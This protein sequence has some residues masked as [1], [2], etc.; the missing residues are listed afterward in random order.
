MRVLFACIENS[1]RSQIAEALAKNISQGKIDFYS[2]GSKP[3]GVV[4]PMAIKLL[5]SQRVH[6]TDH[7]SKHISEFEGIKINYL[8]LMGC[9]DECPNLVV[10]ERIEWDIPDPIDME[11]SEFLKV[12]EKIRGEVQK[13]IATI[14]I[15][16][17][18]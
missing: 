3:S 5:R 2:A 1:C 9:G 10:D 11:K 7:K 16:H 13:L 6:L 8:I 4:N 17:S 12:I 15:E 18:L 14:Y